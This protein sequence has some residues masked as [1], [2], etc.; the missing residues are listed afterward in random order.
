MRRRCPRQPVAQI[1][2]TVVDAHDLEILGVGIVHLGVAVLDLLADQGRVQQGAP[3]QAV[4]PGDQGLQIVGDD[5]VRALVL[6]GVH[7]GRR[8]LAETGG[9][10][11]QPLAV[12]DVEVLF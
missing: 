10:H 11:L 6:E 7:G 8:A 3:G 12:G 5:E 4:H 2:P 1:A 9:Q